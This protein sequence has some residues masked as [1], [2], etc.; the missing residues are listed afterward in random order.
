MVTTAS[1]ETSPIPHHRLGVTQQLGRLV[2]QRHVGPGPGTPRSALQRV[3]SDAERSGAAAAS[4]SGEDQS[5]VSRRSG[6]RSRAR[7]RRAARTARAIT[8]TISEAALDPAHLR[9]LGRGPDHPGE[10][11]A[12][13]GQHD[14]GLPE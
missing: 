1:P 14:L 4:R 10:Q 5:K 9:G 13:G 2:E 6:V 12:D 11:L 7:S 8:S 3:R